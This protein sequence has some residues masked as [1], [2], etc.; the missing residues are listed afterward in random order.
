M[1]ILYVKVMRFDMSVRL[2]YVVFWETERCVRVGV[3]TE[4]TRDRQECWAGGHRDTLNG[5]NKNK[6]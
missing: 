3:K 1:L 5:G 6:H 2:Q 4:K